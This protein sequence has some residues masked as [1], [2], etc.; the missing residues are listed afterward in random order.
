MAL[1]FN[2]GTLKSAGDK[3]RFAAPI[4]TK[5]AILLFYEVAGV[6]L[7]N[8]RAYPIPLP[9]DASWIRGIRGFVLRI[10]RRRADDDE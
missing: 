5:P 4:T 1:C 10:V 3:D 2:S 9:C 6:C 7:I 8:E